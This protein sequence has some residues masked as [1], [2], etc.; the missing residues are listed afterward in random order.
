[1][2][3]FVLPRLLR[4]DS[5]FDHTWSLDQIS[6]LVGH[7]SCVDV[8]AGSGLNAGALPEART[9]VRRLSSTSAPASFRDQ[10]KSTGANRANENIPTRR[11]R[12]GTTIEEQSTG[13]SFLTSSCNRSECRLGTK[14][15]WMRSKVCTRGGKQECASSAVRRAR[16]AAC[17][18]CCIGKGSPDGSRTKVPR[19]C[20]S[21]LQMQGVMGIW[22]ASFRELW[23]HPDIVGEVQRTNEAV[24]EVGLTR[25]LAQ[26][27]LLSLDSLTI[28]N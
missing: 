18:V 2:S 5:C 14:A 24:G 28:V 9:K 22:T 6:L 3:C 27:R 12:V 25:R 26:C 16:T 20:I 4:G 15:E 10:F 7:G 8:H 21:G 23:W 17:W 1:M 11:H 13:S 19:A